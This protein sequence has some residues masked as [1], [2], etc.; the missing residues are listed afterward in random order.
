M[1]GLFFISFYYL[2]RPIF[3]KFDIS[4]R[5]RFFAALTLGLILETALFFITDDAGYYFNDFYSQVSSKKLS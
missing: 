5:I 2:S 1:T 4:D 3:I